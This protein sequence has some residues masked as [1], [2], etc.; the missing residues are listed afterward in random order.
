MIQRMKLTQAT[1]RLGRENRSN[2]KRLQ[3]IQAKNY[4]LFPKYEKT[5]KSQARP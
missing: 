3:Q 2:N 5:Q 4:S 1:I